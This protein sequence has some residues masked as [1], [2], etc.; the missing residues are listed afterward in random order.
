MFAG[1]QSLKLQKENRLL[2][3][4]NLELNKQINPV[5]SELF[6]ELTKQDSPG[7]IRWSWQAEEESKTTG[8]VL[9]D[10]ERQVGVMRFV[11]F[12]PND[13][14]ISQYQLWIFDESQEYP[15]DGGVF[16]ISTDGETFVP[17]HAKL[18]AK[19]P[20]AFAVT[21]ERPDGVVVSKK[22][23]VPLVASAK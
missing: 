15:I 8:E 23:L 7:M 12:Q 1:W 4:Q 22:E 6:A 16:D 19:R 10:Q 17:I 20:K 13:P 5:G 3:D 11:G 9:W 18:M 14:R 2:A 21:V